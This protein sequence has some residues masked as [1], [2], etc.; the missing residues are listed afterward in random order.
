MAES[1]LIATVHDR[2]GVL[3]RIASMFYRRG[4]NIRSL[5]VSGTHR[6][7]IS[8]M[9]VRV[10][11]EPRDVDRLALSIDNLID[12]LSTT[13]VDADETPAEE[14]CLVRL[15]PRSSALRAA[16]LVE[17]ERFGATLQDDRG[18]D[19]VLRVSAPPRRI[20]ELL[21]RLQRVPIVDVSRTGMTTVPAS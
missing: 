2:P 15:A 12:V 16:M 7:G 14:L 18:G 13:L 5:T 19:V 20:D 11:G 17:A 21:E 1:V 8:K 4:L 6:D 10:A 3:A 9:T